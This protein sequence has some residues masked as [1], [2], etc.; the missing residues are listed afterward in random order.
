MADVTG[1]R[2]SHEADLSRQADRAETQHDGQ[3][4]RNGQMRDVHTSI[5]GR[6]RQRTPPRRGI[7]SDW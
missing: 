1:N 7:A 5:A 4:R 2:R 3:R 6:S